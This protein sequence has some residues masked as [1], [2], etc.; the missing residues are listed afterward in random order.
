MESSKV[1]IKEEILEESKEI[2]EC[3]TLP[4]SMAGENDPLAR[5]RVTWIGTQWQF[6]FEFFK[7]SKNTASIIVDRGEGGGRVKILNNGSECFYT[8]TCNTVNNPL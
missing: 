4:L 6:C 5:Y 1:F 8:V 2:F 7:V 3:G